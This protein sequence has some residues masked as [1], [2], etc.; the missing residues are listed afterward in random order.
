MRQ[1]AL[2]GSLVPL[3]CSHRARRGRDRAVL[4]S[5]GVATVFACRCGHVRVRR[6]NLRGELECTDW[7]APEALP[8][9]L[10]PLPSESPK[11]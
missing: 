10:R 4:G 2:D 1:V 11:P 8:L 9:E 6:R 7:L 5:T 3:A